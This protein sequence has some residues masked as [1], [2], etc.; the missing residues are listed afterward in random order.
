VSLKRQLFYWNR[1][2]MDLLLGAVVWEQLFVWTPIDPLDAL[3]VF[4]LDTWQLTY[5]SARCLSHLFMSSFSGLWS[6]GAFG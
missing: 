2:D 3:L 6:I 5:L 4:P 1:D